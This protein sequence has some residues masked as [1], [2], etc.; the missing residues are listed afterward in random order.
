MLIR[1]TSCMACGTKFSACVASGRSVL[2]ENYVRCKTCRHK[3]YKM[4]MRSLK[5]C[6]LCHSPCVAAG[7]GGAAKPA[8]SGPRAGVSV[9]LSGL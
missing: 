2:D 1:D 4:E 9:P 7:A 8:A 5:T 6:P 3:A